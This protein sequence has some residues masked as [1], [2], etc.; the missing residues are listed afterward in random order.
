M[1]DLDWEIANMTYEIAKRLKK[2][3][4]DMKNE[5]KG[6]RDPYAAGLRDGAKEIE[7]AAKLISAGEYEKIS[8]L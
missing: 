7:R 8:W 3:A 4:K 1:T 5:V 2:L 6:E